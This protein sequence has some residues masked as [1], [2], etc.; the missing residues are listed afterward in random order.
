MIIVRVLI[1]AA[2]LFLLHAI[3]QVIDNAINA[4][5]QPLPQI[6]GAVMFIAVAV[7]FIAVLNKLMKGITNE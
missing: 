7:V 4:L 2:G 3:P 5:P 6:I 1:M